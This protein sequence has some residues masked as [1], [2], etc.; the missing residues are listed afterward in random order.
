VKSANLI[1][2]E[3]ATEVDALL[4]QAGPL[5]AKVTILRNN[6]FA[7]RSASI[8]YDDVYKEAAVRPDQLRDLTELA[9]GI[10]NKLLLARGLGEHFFN[11]LP[12]QD[13]EAMLKALAQKEP[14]GGP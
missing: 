3:A 2:P 8:S 5:A 11:E 7:H 9:L 10:A 1:S 12:R 14:V 6:V 13:A 4:S